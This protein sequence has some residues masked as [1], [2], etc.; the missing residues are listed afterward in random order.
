MP[1]INQQLA[2]DL[3]EIETEGGEFSDEALAL[4][5]EKCAKKA[6]AIENYIKLATITVQ[7]NT[8]VSGTSPSGPV[9]G[10]GI[11]VSQGIIT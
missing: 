7:I 4:I 8:T 2:L 9:E 5:K 6:L 3:F 11:G 10:T 1:L